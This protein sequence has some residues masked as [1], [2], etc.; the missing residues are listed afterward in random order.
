MEIKDDFATFPIKSKGLKTGNTY[1][2]SFKVKCLPSPMD[3]I[4]ADVDYRNKMGNNIHLASE[5][6]Q[7]LAFALYQLKYLIVSHDEAP[8]WDNRILPGSHIPDHNIIMEVF[9]KA[10][11]AQQKWMEIK[12][13]RS[14]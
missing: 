3:T 12:E 11:E 9:N 7:H 4:N 1:I 14:C 13:S 2:G 6:A 8:F 5:D 10:I